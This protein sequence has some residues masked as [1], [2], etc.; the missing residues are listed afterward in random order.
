MKDAGVIYEDQIAGLQPADNGS[1]WI[2]EEIGK[3]TVGRVIPFEQRTLEWQRRDR[4]IVVTDGA[5]LLASIHLKHGAFDGKVH[6]GILKAIEDG[7]LTESRKSIG[8]M[9]AHPLRSSHS[10]NELT[11]SSAACV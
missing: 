4:A 1:R 10:V 3:L 7:R 5:E 6:A 11:F 8:I 2:A 9:G